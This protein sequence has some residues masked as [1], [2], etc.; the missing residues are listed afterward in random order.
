MPHEN[1]EIVF[2]LSEFL[3]ALLR[4]GEMRGGHRYRAHDIRQ[5]G[6]DPSGGGTAELTFKDDE[7]VKYSESDILAG[8]IAY[9]I[10]HKVPLPARAGK[11]V[12]VNDDG[13]TLAVESK[14]DWVP[15]VDLPLT[16][17]PGRG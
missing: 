9:C 3:D 7:K 11:K 4:Y 14:V 5:V 17:K 2:S 6:V 10:E 16:M 12:R 1:R 15:P 13:V 8:L